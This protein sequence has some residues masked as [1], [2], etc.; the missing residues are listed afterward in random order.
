[1]SLWW[2]PSGSLRSWVS[3]WHWTLTLSWPSSIK[4]R[5]QK[6][7][8]RK[9]NRSK[10]P[11][12]GR[13]HSKA[14]AWTELGECTFNVSSKL[15]AVYSKRAPNKLRCAISDTICFERITVTK[16]KNVGKASEMSAR[17]LIRV[18]PNHTQDF[19]IDIGLAWEDIRARCNLHRVWEE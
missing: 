9:K 18:R 10:L 8:F 14:N 1:M 16:V 2:S 19:T 12:K 3:L 5:S 11:V 15:P 4:H 6:L 17:I 13:L 7:N